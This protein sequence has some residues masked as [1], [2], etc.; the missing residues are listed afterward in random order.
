MQRNAMWRPAKVG[1]RT[2]GSNSIGALLRH[3]VH[4]GGEANWYVLLRLQ[5]T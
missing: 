5:D 3:A 2:W 1:V 4:Q